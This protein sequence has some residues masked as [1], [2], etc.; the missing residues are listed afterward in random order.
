MTGVRKIKAREGL[1]NICQH[2]PWESI[3][4]KKIHQCQENF[5]KT[6]RTSQRYNPKDAGNY[7]RQIPLPY[8]MQKKNKMDG[9]DRMKQDTMRTLP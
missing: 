2:K 9:R 3:P 5:I 1:K 6:K 7:Q 8:G 4:E